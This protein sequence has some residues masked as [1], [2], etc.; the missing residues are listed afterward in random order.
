[1]KERNLRLMNN[2]SNVSTCELGFISEAGKK[3]LEI[4]AIVEIKVGV[5]NRL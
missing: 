1:M 4:C 5:G 2:Y 3:G